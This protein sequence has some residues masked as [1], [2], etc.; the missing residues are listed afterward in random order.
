[1]DEREFWAR[2]E[3]RISEEFAGFADNHLRFYWCDGLVP[4]QYDVAAGHWRIRG[5][6]WIGQGHQQERWAFTLAAGRARGTR[7][8]IG[9]SALLPAGTLTGWLSPDPGEKHVRIDPA[10]GYHA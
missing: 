7:E 9:W 1:M 6:A 4:E 2:L 10:A 8:D 5:F 3:Y